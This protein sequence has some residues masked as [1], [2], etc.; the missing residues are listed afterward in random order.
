MVR[1]IHNL[2]SFQM[3]LMSVKDLVCNIVAKK[4]DLL[5]SYSNF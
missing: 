4:K 3:A 2:P 1:M 5:F